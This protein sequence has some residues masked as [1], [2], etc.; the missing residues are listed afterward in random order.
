VQQHVR[1]EI[2]TDFRT[3]GVAMPIP[4]NEAPDGDHDPHPMLLIALAILVVAWLVV[5]VVVLGL[6]ASAAA[7]DR[8]LGRPARGPRRFRGA[9]RGARY[10]AGA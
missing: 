2:R 10:A 7:G 9:G 4:G 5:A 8:A 3:F 6:C 1:D